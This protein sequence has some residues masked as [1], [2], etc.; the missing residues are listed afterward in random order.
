MFIKLY[1]AHSCLR[2]KMGTPHQLANGQRET[3][4]IHE[5][6]CLSFLQPHRPRGSRYAYEYQKYEIFRGCESPFNVL[7]WLAQGTKTFVSES[8]IYAS[9]QSLHGA[10]CPLMRID[11]YWSAD[12]QDREGSPNSMNMRRSSPT[13]GLGLWLRPALVSIPQTWDIPVS[14]CTCA[15]TH[16]HVH[17]LCQSLLCRLLTNI[18]TNRHHIL[19][20]IPPRIPGLTRAQHADSSRG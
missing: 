15:H 3:W 8:D 10:D 4:L 19:K 12:S 9:E 13:S 14:K 1:K 7:A 17:T 18:D 6:L 16:T 5:G 2:Y 20:E 11:L